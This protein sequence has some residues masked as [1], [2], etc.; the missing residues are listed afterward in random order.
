MQREME[1]I[2][3]AGAAP[4]SLRAVGGSRFPAV[5]LGV[6]PESVEVYAFLPGIDPAALEVSVHQGLL[7]IAGERPPA[8]PE[9]ATD[10]YQQERFSG[11]FRRTVSLPEDVDPERIEAIYRDGVLRVRAH[12]RQAAQPR[13]VSVT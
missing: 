13:R 5:N 2:L 8:S 10:V 12:K 6:T 11:E 9:G 4:A 1:Q 3:G 7:V